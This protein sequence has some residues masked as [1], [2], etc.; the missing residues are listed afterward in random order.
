MG[1]IDLLYSLKFT[2]TQHRDFP[3]DPEVKTSLPLQGL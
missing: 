1:R 3:G 2:L